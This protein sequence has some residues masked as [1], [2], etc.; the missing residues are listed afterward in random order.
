MRGDETPSRPTALV[1]GAAAEL[2]MSETQGSQHS[3][4]QNKTIAALAR[5][6]PM[7][8]FDRIVSRAGKRPTAVRTG[9]ADLRA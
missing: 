9:D 6:L 2:A 4:W 1:T 7:R 3:G 5:L 8:L